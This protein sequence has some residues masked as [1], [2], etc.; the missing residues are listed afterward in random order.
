MKKIL[1]SLFMLGGLLSA[2]AQYQVANSSFETWESVSYTTSSGTAVTGEEPTSWSSFITGTGSLKDVAA[3]N[4]V[5]KSTEK[6]TG[7]TGTYCAKISSRA[8]KFGTWV[9]ALAQGNLTTGCINMGSITASDA[10]GNYNYTN[11]DNAGQNQPFT[12]KPD[13]MHVWIK[14]TTTTTYKGKVSTVLHT[15]GYYQDPEANTLTAKV[16]AKAV[17]EA[18]S[19]SADWQE[20][21]LP[22]TYT[23]GVTDRPAYALVSFATSS[24]AGKGGESDYMLI[25]DLEYLYYSKL[26][27]LAYDGTSYFDAS[28]TAYDLS[29][30]VYD[31]AKLVVTSNG[32]AATIERSY[33]ATTG[34]LTLTVKGDNWSVDNSN[35]NVYTV[36]FKANQPIV[37][38]YTNKLS[39]GV[40]GVTN[41]TQDATIQLIQE[42]DNSYSFQLKNFM[43]SGTPIGTIKVTNLVK[44]GNH[45]TKTANISIVAGDD[46]AGATW[47]GPMLGEIP[48]VLDANVV[49][50]S[51]T[52]QV[53]IDLSSQIVNVVVAPELNLTGNG[54]AITT[55]LKNVKLSRAFSAG[56]NTISLPFDYTI[57]AFGD[58]YGVKMAELTS[59]SGSI[60]NFSDVKTLK[61]NTP[62]L[63]YFATA[64]IDPFYF[65]VKIADATA[66]SVTKDSYV[67]SSTYAPASTENKFFFQTDGTVKKGSSTDVVPATGAY[68]TTD[69]PA[70]EVVINGVS[71]GIED[72]I[73]DIPQVY[74]VYNINGVKVLENAKSL[75][76]LE[77]GF[78]IVNGRKTVIR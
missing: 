23:D 2:E 15:S 12:G 58:K 78:Y 49:D 18:V 31:P 76:G 57:A 65:G 37:T 19:P 59:A 20:I 6:R 25:D 46:P 8:V 67:I 63:I 7:A 54:E 61:A 36:Q 48:V 53:N 72:V 11:L 74:N 62:Y 41:P 22:F 69:Q 5:E 35:Q 66:Q 1:L 13:A 47:I 26:A 77:K 73:S 38:N 14:F 39:V 21:T 52:A 27:T 40:D 24:T 56:W 16:V 68:L 30:K 71:T 33:N 75:N 9:A 55:G 17:N 42:A 10:K 32:V 60:V 34:L 50:N 4:Q 44:D 28:K 29:D 43:L 64:P 45:Y 3:A 70:V 51:M